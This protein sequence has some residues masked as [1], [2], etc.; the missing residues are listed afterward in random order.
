MKAKKGAKVSR[1]KTHPAVLG[2]LV[3]GGAMAG[4]MAAQPDVVELPAPD[5]IVLPAPEPEKVEVPVRFEEL[6]H[7]AD[8]SLRKAFNLSDQAKN[9]DVVATFKALAAAN[10]GLTEENAALRADNQR[11]VN[12]HNRLLKDVQIET[13]PTEVEKYYQNRSLEGT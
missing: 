5:P 8:S 2:A 4:N 12:A 10:K 1:K 9:S 3:V 13:E 11:I 7:R 6:T